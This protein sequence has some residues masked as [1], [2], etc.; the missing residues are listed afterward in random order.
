MTVKKFVDKKDIMTRPNDRSQWHSTTILAL[1][2]GGKV[3][4]AG[5][6]RASLGNTVLK[7]NAR[8]ARRLGKEGGVVTGFAGGTADA[9]TLFERLEA[10]LEAHPGQLTRACVE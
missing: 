9:F 8:K 7:S 10:K 1:R 3:I 6:G 2:K 5:D 4:V